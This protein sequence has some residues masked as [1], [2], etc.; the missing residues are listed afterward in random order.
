MYGA[1]PPDTVTVAAPVDWPKHNTLVRSLIT[2]DS[3]A[4]GWVMVTVN[5][6]KQPLTILYQL[7]GKIEGEHLKFLKTA[8][9]R[10][11]DIRL[12]NCSLNIQYK[13]GN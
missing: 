10:E 13:E 3:G 6:L 11:A 5:V 9:L 8:I 7:N 12:F 2:A 4:C 1:V